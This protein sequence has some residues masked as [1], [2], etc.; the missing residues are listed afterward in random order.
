MNKT[1]I[2]MLLMFMYVAI[3][4]YLIISFVALSF[5]LYDWT[6]ENRLC[7]SVAV[8]IISIVMIPM[9][10]IAESPQSNQ[11]INISSW[12]SVVEEPK[13]TSLQHISKEVTHYSKEALRL[14]Q[15]AGIVDKKGKLTKKYRYEA[16]KKNG[17]DTGGR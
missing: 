6:F 14:L 10:L 13:F 1:Q 17:L 2:H 8:P 3:V 15:K 11:R 5:S 4:M 7:F 12:Q 16:K 9:V